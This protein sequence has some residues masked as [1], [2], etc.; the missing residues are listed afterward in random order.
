LNKLYG[1]AALLLVVLVLTAANS[2]D[3]DWVANFQNLQKWTAL[4][5]FLGIGV[6][7]VIITGGID[8]SLGSV[9]ALVGVLLIVTINA[10][11]PPALAVASMLALS[12]LL[13]LAHG[14]LVTRVRLQ[15]FVVTLCGLLI[16]RGLA[17]RIGDD[18]PQGLDRSAG[19]DFGALT[20]LATGKPLGAPLFLVLLGLVLAAAGL[21]VARRSGPPAARANARVVCGLGVVSALGGVIGLAFGGSVVGQVRVPAPFLMMTIVAVLAGLFLSCTVWGRHLIALGKNEE[22]AR[23][24]GIRTQ[25]LVVLAYVIC[26][27]LT[28]L[29]AVLFALGTPSVQPGIHG[30]FYELYAIAAAVLGGCSLRGGEGSIVGVV[31]GTALL[32]VLLNAITLLGLEQELEFAIIGAVILIG[33][34]GDELVRRALARRRATRL[35]A[36]RLPDKETPT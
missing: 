26:T 32:R 25:R 1:L 16:Y 10:G 30:N 27:S 34:S 8:L 7:F 15:P 9:V 36:A 13:G 4:F 2:P 24:S 35:A 21:W 18:T 28:G 5:G 33:V 3:A 14:L 22:A 20:S 31:L 17:R 6:A 19:Q 12:A 23:F 29:G 11:V